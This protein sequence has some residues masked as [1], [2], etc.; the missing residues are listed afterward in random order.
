V[1]YKGQP[2]VI[3][4]YRLLQRQQIFHDALSLLAHAGPANTVH[5]VSEVEI[6]GG[7][8]DFFL[9]SSQ[10]DTIEDYLALEIQTLDTTG[11][12]WPAR[13]AFIREHIDPAQEVESKPYGI[14]WKM[15]AKTILVQMHHKA[16]S[17]VRLGKKIVLVIQDGLYSYIEKEFDTSRLRAADPGD[18]VQ[19]HVYRVE[20]ESSG[21]FVLRLATRYSTTLEGVEVMLGA[22][23]SSEISD[24]ELKARLQAKINPQN[25]LKA[26]FHPDEAHRQ[27]ESETPPPQIASDRGR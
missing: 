16:E 7:T 10:N 3:C 26:G 14:N 4:P 19:I 27:I 17:V 6:P 25:I 20:Q 2:V 23:R 22:R 15:T 9:V 21:E 24:A 8:V 12:V 13:Q 11:T 1:A 5:V 18:P